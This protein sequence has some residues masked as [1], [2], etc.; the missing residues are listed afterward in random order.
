VYR[1]AGRSVR[2]QVMKSRLVGQFSDR[3]AELES[4]G[5]L[6]RPDDRATRRVVGELACR[7][8]VPFVDASSNDYLGYRDG[9]PLEGRALGVSRETGV[10][11]GGA[12]A[13]R[14]LGGSDEWHHALER[15]LAEWVS[16]ETSLLFSSGYS[17]NVGAL[18]ALLGDQDVLFSDSLNHASII[19]GARLSKARVVVYEHSDLDHLARLLSSTSCAANRWVATESYFSMDG[20]CPD[21]LQL[22]TLA[23]CSGAGLL[24]DE[25]HALGVFGPRGAGLCAQL[26]ITADVLVGTFGKSLGTQGA[27]L[28]SP[29]PIRT[30]LWNRARSFVYSTATSPLLA[31]LTL[32][33]LHQAQSDDR[34]RKRLEAVSSRVR[35]ELNAAGIP[36]LPSSRGPIVPILVGSVERAMTLSAVLQ[37]R[38][39]V[40]YAIRPPTVPRDTARIRLTLRASFTDAIVSHLLTELRAAWNQTSP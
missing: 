27:F 21:L 26:G 19:D 4:C 23:D 24:V 25:A 8:G 6:R 1:A 28:A 30:W 34:S 13:S 14:L 32:Q 10:A 40:A 2:E 22:R 7:L 38:G 37:S 29:A 16:Q 31:W 12:G 33:R 3:V 39:I 35:N 5:L 11:T 18:S 15:A 9:D 17:A 36:V 20:D